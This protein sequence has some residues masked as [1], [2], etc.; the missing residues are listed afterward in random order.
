[1]QEDCARVLMFRGAEKEQKNSTG[2]SAY[3]VAI[4]ASY[5][6]LADTIHKFRPDDVGEILA[7]LSLTF[8]SVLLV[9]GKLRNIWQNVF[10]K[11]AVF[12]AKN[13]TIVRAYLNR[14]NA[15]LFTVFI[16]C[17]STLV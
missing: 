16:Y 12:F 14:L 15:H 13:G 6:N 17:F 5:H 4:A 11:I 8:G 1:M 9:N 7:L 2:H 3:Q 10:L